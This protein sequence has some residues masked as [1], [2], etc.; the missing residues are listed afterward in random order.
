MILGVRAAEKARA[1]ALHQ[2]AGVTIMISSQRTVGSMPTRETALRRQ[3][4]PGREMLI[5]I[6]TALL[7]GAAIAG[8]IIIMP[9]A[10]AQDAHGGT[11]LLAE[12]QTGQRGARTI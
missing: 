6:L 11:K 9:H 1:G 10:A 7:I 5:Q 8:I 2:E 4:A 12:P 3:A